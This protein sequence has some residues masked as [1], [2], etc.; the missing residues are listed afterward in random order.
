M[1][2][3]LIAIE[4]IDGSGTSTQ[5]EL[6]HQK[7]IENEIPSHLV[8]EPSEGPAGALL[9]QI[10]RRR[11]VTLGTAGYHPPGAL[12]QALLF[13]ADRRDL[14]EAEVGPNLNDGINVISDRSVFSSL[15]YQSVDGADLDWLVEINR[16]AR[17]PDLTIIL[18]TDPAVAQ[19]RRTARRQQA[20]IFDED[21][22]QAKLA[23]FYRS[24]PSKFTK[25]RFE[26]IDGA[27]PRDLVFAACYRAVEKHLLE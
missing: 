24:L 15:A 8:S 2:G 17:W 10:L 4:G 21:D 25:Y 22:I 27:A 26:I 11:L 23:E 1:N 16:F 13:A 20:E 19:A 6:V 5:A 3:Q 7:L 9:R 18:D 12:T 14:F